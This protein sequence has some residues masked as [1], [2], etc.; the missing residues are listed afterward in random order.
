[1]RL[2]VLKNAGFVAMDTQWTKCHSVVDYADNRGSGFDVCFTFMS[3]APGK[4]D[5]I[6]A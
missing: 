1:M 3:L 6:H 4:Q 2:R 5:L